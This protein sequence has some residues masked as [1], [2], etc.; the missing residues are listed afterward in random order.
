MKAAVCIATYNRYD[1]LTKT[2]ESVLRSDLSGIEQIIIVDQ[3]SIDMPSVLRTLLHDQALIHYIKEETPSLTKA[4]NIGI[5]AASRMADIIIFIDDDVEVVPDFFLHHIHCYTAPEILAVGGREYIVPEDFWGANLETSTP[6]THDDLFKRLLNRALKPVAVL[7][8]KR[9]RYGRN[10]IS[11]GIV[12]GGWLFA[13]VPSCAQEPCFMDTVRGCNMSFRIQPIMELGGFDEQFTK[14]ARR[15]ESDVCFTIREALGKNHIRFQPKALVFH[16]MVSKGGCRHADRLS[17]D[18]LT[19]EL[20]FIR[21]HISHPIQLFL[22]TQYTKLK[23]L[24]R[25]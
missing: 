7:T 18:H 23:I 17:S 25:E 11:P 6:N 21:K 8:G 3:S 15:E 24:L 1:A 10:A 12:F 2:L 19:N 16:H 14:S 22:L 13:G 4:R 20:Y 5:K 9:N